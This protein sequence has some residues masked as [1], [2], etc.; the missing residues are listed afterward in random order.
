M[1]ANL[2]HIEQITDDNDEPSHMYTRYSQDIN[3]KNACILFT[4][5]A[6]RVSE[7][8]TWKISPFLFDRKEHSIPAAR[9]LCQ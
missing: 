7:S 8:M 9:I 5:E 3:V 2:K 6:S 4:D 1:A